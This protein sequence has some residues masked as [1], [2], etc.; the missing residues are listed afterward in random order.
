M[1][2]HPLCPVTAL[3]R[4]LLLSQSLPLDAPLFAYPVGSGY[5]ALSYQHFNKHLSQHIRA[6]GIPS[7]GYTSHSFRRGGA[8]YMLKA[9]IPADVIQVLGDWKSDCYKIY[10][11]FDVQTKLSMLHPFVESLKNSE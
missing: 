9:G 4:L 5:K 2:G 1:G 11:E 3:T 8:S 6:A 7:S 10:L